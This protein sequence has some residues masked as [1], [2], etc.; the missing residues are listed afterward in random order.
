MVSVDV[1]SVLTALEGVH[2]PHVPV[3]LRAM[4]MLG[5]VSVADDG[6]VLVQVRLPCLACPGT[7]MIRERVV[8]EVCAV[9][10]VT[11]C[12]VDIDGSLMWDAA[13]VDEPARRLMQTHGIQ[14]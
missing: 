8:E 13:D 11:S 4:G 1:G 6:R 9:G 3:S 2:D 10:G 12:E 5:D 7:T 14:L